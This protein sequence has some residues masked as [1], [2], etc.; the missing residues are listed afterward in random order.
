MNLFDKSINVLRHLNPSYAEWVAS[1]PEDPGFELVKNTAGRPNLLVRPEGRD[2]FLL[3]ENENFLEQETEI[4]KRAAVEPKKATFLFGLGLGYR[5]EALLRLLPGDCH[6][7]VVE[8]NPYLVRLALSVTNLIMALSRGRLILV[9][10]DDQVLTRFSASLGRSY[11]QGETAVMVDEKC[12]KYFTP[13]FKNKVDKFN[14][15]VRRDAL[16]SAAYLQNAPKIVENELANLPLTLISP[17]ISSLKDSLHGLP[18]IVVSAGP[19]LNA[20]IHLLAE[21][22]GRAALIATAPVLR[23]LLAFDVMPDL[24]GILDYTPSNYD[25]LA[26]AFVTEDVPLV[27]LEATWPKV[28]R[29]YQGD[30]VSIFHS[31]GPVRNWLGPLLSGR[32][33]WPVGSNVGSFCLDLAIYLGADPIILVGQDFS[34][35]ELVT[36]SEGVVGRRKVA[37]KN[38]AQDWIWLDAVD[39]GRVPSSLALASYLEEFNRTIARTERTFINTSPFGARIEGTLEMG[40]GQALETYCQ[41]EHNITSLI[42]KG[43]GRPPDDLSAL[44][45]EL[46]GLDQELENLAVVTNKTLEFNND[47][48]EM[49]EAADSP[50]EENLKTRMEVHARYTRGTRKYWRV[51]VPLKEFMASS[52][53]REARPN[54]V[55]KN[56][57][58]WKQEIREAMAENRGLIESAR[59][60]VLTLRPLLETARNELKDLISAENNSEGLPPEKTD[61]LAIGRALAGLGR[62]KDAWP[63]YRAALSEKPEDKDLLVEAARVCLG[64]ERPRAAQ[65]LVKNVLETDPDH[66]EAQ[67]ALGSIKSIVENWLLRAEKLIDQ[68]EWVGSMLTARK[69]LAYDP[70]NPRA[71]QVENRCR[72]IRALR[73]AEAEK[74]ALASER[75]KT[76]RILVSRAAEA[77]NQGRFQETIDLLTGRLDSENPEDLEG[78]VLLGSGLAELGRLD[79][80]HQLLNSVIEKRPDWRLVQVRLA[81]IL[82][83]KGATVCGLNLLEKAGLNSNGQKALLFEAGC[84]SMKMGDYD[85]AISDFEEHLARF[86]DSPETMNKLAICHLARGR[87]RSA[88]HYFEKVMT[89][90]PESQAAR[91]GLEKCMSLETV[92][93]LE[94][95]GFGQ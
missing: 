56:R 91:L 67:K 85:R 95:E 90:N 82:L 52:L 30:L 6:V 38:P 33:H 34:F 45:A 93:V 65:E 89:I 28:V 11:R 43:L 7:L 83:R 53:T 50:E 39:G 12:L 24:A 79:E 20:G 22:Y 14:L 1:A 10:N 78:L 21:A 84:L 51:F 9:P 4:L 13:A 54:A 80:G 26:D 16:G 55:K 60:G 5:A 73:T 81:R 48:L 40:L 72:E 74:L 76:N 46:C 71:R 58:D 77:F 18:A 17:G 44:W 88:R 8:E 47:I 23:V 36:H 64:R 86:A 29:D 19:S 57:A 70:E 42:R 62:L 41:K 92:K 3:Y 75:R 69:V 15:K 59:D 68:A 49:L 66:Q 35:P 31:H 94:K 32:D 87:H 27:F 37:S 61:H 2:G 63:H 25:V